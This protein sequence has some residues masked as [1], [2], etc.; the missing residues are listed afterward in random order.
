MAQHPRSSERI[1]YKPGML[2]GAMP[3]LVKYL[4]ISYSGQV[5]LPP[6]MDEEE[7]VWMS[8]LGW[9]YSPIRRILAS[10][11]EQRL[12]P[13]YV[14]VNDNKAIGYT[15]FS[16]HQHKGIIG[17]LFA[18]KTDF[19]S[20]VIAE[21]LSL[22]VAN[23]K[24]TDSIQRVEAQIIPFNNINPAALF[25][26]HGYQYYPRYYLELDL[27]SF[28]GTVK[29][30]ADYTITPWDSAYLPLAAEVTARSY[31]NQSDAEICEDYRSTAGCEGYLNSIIENPGCGIFIPEGSFISLDKRGFPCG[32]IICCR[33]SNY[34]G[35]IPQISVHPSFQGCG[36]GNALMYHSLHHLKSHGFRTASL[37]VTKKNRRAFE[38]YQHLGFKLRK[39]FGAY[40]WQR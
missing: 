25:M 12:L 27:D 23:L 29:A 1:S 16:I 30:P 9:D 28:S 5:L 32:F 13:G 7:K 36:L 4:P 35:M 22:S 26:Q 10:Y 34:A 39:E 2:R 21:L 14:A 6:L 8:E 31:Q 40:V 18:L 11:I 17:A 3:N 24:E 37:T 33:I 20:E 15:Y 19:S 38:W